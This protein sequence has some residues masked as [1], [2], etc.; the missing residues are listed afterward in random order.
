MQKK[1]YKLDKVM[2]YATIGLI[3]IIAIAYSTEIITL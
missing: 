3:I 1:L 2:M